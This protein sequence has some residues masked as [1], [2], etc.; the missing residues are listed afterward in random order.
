MNGTRGTRRAVIAGLAG[1]AGAGILAA[2]GAGSTGSGQAGEGATKQ[3]AQSGELVW[4]IA[5][6]GEAGGQAWFTDTL[7]KSFTAD[8]PK[9]QVTFLFHSWGD[10][11][12]KRDTL[13]AAGSGPDLLQSGSSPA[14][15]Y[16]KLVIPLDE[17]LK[18]WK[19]FGDYFPSTLGTSQWQGKQY[20]VPAHDGGW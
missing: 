12:T 20:G 6:H 10:L 9:V 4:M 14:V 16:Q 19:E 7:A 3:S 1:A 11:G 2:C 17:R 5:D 13:Y 18:K 15:A 8:R